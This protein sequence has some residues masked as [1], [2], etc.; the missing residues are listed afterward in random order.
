MAD[1]RQ[2]PRAL[3]THLGGEPRFAHLFLQAQPVDPGREP[4]DERFEQ[5]AIGSGEWL[6][7]AREQ[8]D[9]RAVD[10]HVRVH[11][12]VGRREGFA[13]GESARL[14]REE[15]RKRVGRAMQRVVDVGAG[16]QAVRQVEAD[17]GLGLAP[18]RG[19]AQG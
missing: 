3:A 15:R 5:L 16:E 13:G 12:F 14:E 9:A 17:L 18:E 7:R 4:G 8:G 19:E 11:G 6:R 2:E 1:R 10:P